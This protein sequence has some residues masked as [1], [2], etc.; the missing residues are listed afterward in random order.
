MVRL[1]LAHESGDDAVEGAALVGELDA[2]LGAL[3]EGALGEHVE[4][5]RCAGDR[6]AVEA[7]LDASGGLLVDLDVE[8]NL[9][10]KKRHFYKRGGMVDSTSAV[11]TS[12]IGIAG[13]SG[14]NG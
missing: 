7:H 10:E 4:V 12:P 11:A 13:D 8:E 3:A 1:T 5:L 2:R 6:L 14:S 9:P